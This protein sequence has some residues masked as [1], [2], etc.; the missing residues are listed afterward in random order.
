M[1]VLF[2]RAVR[3]LALL[4]GHSDFAHSAAGAYPL[5]RGPYVYGY[6]YAP[7]GGSTPAAAGG[8]AAKLA[9]LS[10]PPPGG[11][12]AAAAAASLTGP[13]AVAAADATWLARR[14]HGTGRV[15]ARRAYA[16]LMAVLVAIGATALASATD[17]AA[18]LAAAAPRT[19]RTVLWAVRASLS[20]KRFQV[21]GRGR[22]LCCLCVPA[23]T[24]AAWAEVWCLC[25]CWGRGGP[26]QG[27]AACF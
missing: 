26:V 21:R 22:V 27:P 18:G 23:V 13:A 6:P 7:Y 2:A 5:Y 24:H 9:S 11:S 25:R 19:L 20:Y 17:A 1:R 12:A 14:V 10:V 15:V 4:R 16:T 8:V 3:Y